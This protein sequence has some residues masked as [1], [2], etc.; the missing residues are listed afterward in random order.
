MILITGSTG[1][2]GMAFR[3]LKECNQFIF[4]DTSICDLTNLEETKDYFAR[5]KLQ[6]EI[7]AIIHLAAK[8]GGVKLSQTSPADL[9]TVNLQMAMNILNVAKDAAIPRVILALSTSCY[10]SNLVNPRE[11]QILEGEISSGDYAYA[12]AKR[13]FVP[14]MKSFNSQ[15]S[16][17]ITCSV[18]NGVVG[19]Y[20]NFK[21]E[22]STLVPALIRRIY[23]EKSSSK[24]V[25]VWGDGSPLR[26]YTYSEDLARALIWTIKGQ[27]IGTTLNIGNTQKISVREVAEIICKSFEISTDRLYFDRSKPNGRSIQ[28]TDNSNFVLKSNFKYKTPQEAIMIA[29]NWFKSAIENGSKIRI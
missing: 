26:E 18:I 21:D 20:M 4:S 13:M 5:L 7:E 15:F 23:S 16:M 8:S 2:L 25:T 28:S 14:L 3:G 11:D 27:D 22:E 19:P 9:I 24:Q 29:S 1:P 10:S 17:K 12:Y 6:S